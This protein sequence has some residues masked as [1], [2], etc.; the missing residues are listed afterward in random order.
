MIFL[1][2]NRELKLMREACIIAARGLKVAYPYMQAGVSTL[3]INNAIHKEIIANGAKASFLGLYDFPA[4][5]CISVNEQLIHGIPSAKTILKDGDIVSVD[6][7]AFYNGFHGDNA[8]T[9]MVGEVA[10]ET[11]QLLLV[12]QQ[13]LERA[14]EVAVVGNRIGDISHAVES[15]ARSFGY[16]V[17]K[18][19]VGHGVG[20]VLHEAPEVP[21]YGRPGRG[22]RLVPGMTIA[23]EPMINM[24]GDEV[25]VAKDGWAVVSKSNSPTAHFEHTIAITK[26]G[27][28][29]LTLC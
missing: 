9:Y 21:N 24:K 5:A 19:Y 1:K 17:V 28:K 6:V 8:F 13:C 14:I 7:G 18:D 29:I 22:E 25:E 27:A 2:N 11:K 15:H 4:S 12:T 20:R 3:E 10:D 26:E 23:I 16:G